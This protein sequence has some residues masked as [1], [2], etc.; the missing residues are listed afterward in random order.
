MNENEQRIKGNRTYKDTVFR[1]LFRQK[2]ELLSLYNA[3]NGS[4]Y[5]DP[6]E[7]EIVTLDNA[8]Y[9]NVKNDLAFLADFHLYLYEH[10]STVN[11]N[12]PIRF[13]QYVAKEYEK[14]IHGD[15]L[16]RS[17]KVLIPAPQFVVFY[18]GVDYLP[19]KSEL[20]LS[21]AYGVNASNPQL[22]LKVQILN[23]N[24]GNNE[25]LKEQCCLLKEYMMYVDCVRKN[26]EKMSIEEAVSW[27]VDECIRQGIL[28]EF[29]V[30]N[31]AEVVPMSIFE[32]N[33]EETLKLIRADE[34]ELGM[35][36][37]IQQGIA[38]GIAQS[39]GFLIESYAELGISKQDAFVKI[40][41]KFHLEE[42]ELQKYMEEYWK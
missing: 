39:I 1:M 25:K 3:M 8:V 5:S 27:A 9:M 15:S 24:E 11:P 36:K 21:E 14:L 23:I 2:R 22:E 19:E 6:D 38:Q 37:G 13:L 32:Y 31:K 16:Y 7:L 26:A 34:F 10:Q 40:Q 33:E 28:A 41:E 4:N 18:N 35:E 20:R 17:K 30:Q 12:M 29:L 42:D